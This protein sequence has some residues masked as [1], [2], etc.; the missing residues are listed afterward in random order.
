MGQPEL[1]STAEEILVEHGVEIRLAQR[2]HGRLTSHL[3]FGTLSDHH[4]STLPGP[5]QSRW[6]HMQ[7]IRKCVTMSM[8]SLRILLRAWAY[9]GSSRPWST[10]QE[11][12][13]GFSG[14]W[15]VNDILIPIFNHPGIQRA[16]RLEL[17]S[18]SCST[19]WPCAGAVH[20]HRPAS[21]TSRDR[22][23]EAQD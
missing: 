22:K 8:A 16:W 2:S 9:T 20:R 15:M 17:V 13:T 7:C 11:S 4:P 6:V 1:R 12:M 3:H 18:L 14:Y 21:P 19:S 5:G 23:S 10:A